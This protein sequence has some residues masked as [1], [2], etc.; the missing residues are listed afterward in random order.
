MKNILI[1]VCALA[2]SGC[3]TV[4][5]TIKK[6]AKTMETAEKAGLEEVSVPGKYTSTTFKDD[7]ERLT[8]THGNPLLAP[9][10]KMKIVKKKKTTNP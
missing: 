5:S 1:L 7:G 4:N 9:G 8:V 2:L 6:M 3:S 10:E